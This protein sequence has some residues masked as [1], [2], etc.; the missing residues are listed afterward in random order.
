MMVQPNLASLV[1]L[2]LCCVATVAAADEAQRQAAWKKIEAAFH[3]PAEYANDFGDYRSPLVFNDGRTVG[4]PADWQRRRVEILQ[5]W[6]NLMGPWPPIIENQV[7]E[8]LEKVDR[9][10]YVQQKVRFSITPK[11]KTEGYLLLPHGPED[12]TKRK[13]AVLVVFYEP[14]TA[15]G[16]GAGK[17]HR[18]FARQLANRGFVCLSIGHSAS[19][20][21]PDKEDAALQPLSALAYVAANCYHV[22]AN[23]PDVDPK[24]IGVVGHSYGGKWA[25]FAS[26]LFDKFACA[27]YSD[28]GIVFDE[29]RPNVNYWEPWYLGYERDTTRKP[30]VINPERPRTGAYKQMVADGRD[31]HEL[32]ALMAPRPFLVSGGSEDPPSRWQ[33]LNHAVAVNKLLGYENR[34]A[35]T[36]RPAHDPN[37]ESNDVLCSFFEY[38]LLHGGLDQK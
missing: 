13:P 15:I 22:L 7:L 31:L 23:R 32:H 10:K 5:T 26:C 16:E 28:P 9:G 2:L 17:Q 37:D 36:N 1:G 14:E 24:R 3:P 12:K 33:A 11:H 25:M 34:V 8:L 6:H 38:F 21:Y 19:V 29:R 30:G 20:Y 27:A 4:S 18:D 35:M